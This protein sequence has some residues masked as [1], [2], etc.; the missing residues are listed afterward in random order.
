M[1]KIFIKDHEGKEIEVNLDEFIDHI[2]Q[3]H[4]TGTSIH[5]ENGHYFTV[6]DNFRKK[7]K[8]RKTNKNS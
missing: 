7:L 5:D 4:K 8:E 3:F 1:K 6:N 2:N